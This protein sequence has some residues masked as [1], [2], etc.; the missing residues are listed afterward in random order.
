MK[1]RKCTN[2]IYTE[3]DLRELIKKDLEEKDI[4]TDNVNDID[5]TRT[6]WGEVEISVEVLEDGD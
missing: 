2:Y 6:E 1:V 3:S 4:S 5:F